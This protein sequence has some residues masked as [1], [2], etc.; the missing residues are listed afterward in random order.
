[1]LFSTRLGSTPGKVHPA[2]RSSATSA[3]KTE[4]LQLLPKVQK[5][6]QVLHAYEQFPY[7]CHCKIL[8]V[9]SFQPQL[10]KDFV[11]TPGFPTMA[12][13]FTLIVLLKRGPMPKKNAAKK[14]E[15]SSVSKTWRSRAL[16][17]HNLDLVGKNTKLP[18]LPYFS[19]SLFIYYVQFLYKS[20]DKSFVKHL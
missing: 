12:T 11:L 18:I 2:Q 1:M 6:H 14:E 19:P 7:D 5:I 15:T 20:L 10:S 13:A 3:T 4:L 9:S 17:F 8:R 16:S